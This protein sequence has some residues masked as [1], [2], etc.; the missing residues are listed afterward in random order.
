[1]KV[2][3]IAA[4]LIPVYFIYIYFEGG[5]KIWECTTDLVN[6][7]HEKC[8]NF[9]NKRVLDLGCGAGILGLFTLLKGARVDFQ[10]YVG[11][12]DVGKKI[13]LFTFVF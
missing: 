12:S 2:R 6:Y 9:S 3:K 5:L 7:L 11:S 10:D 4:N 8:I 13:C 1:M